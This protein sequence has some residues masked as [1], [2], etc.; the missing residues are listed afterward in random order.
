MAEQELEESVP[1]RTQIRREVCYSFIRTTVLP[2]SLTVG[3]S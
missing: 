3:L 1:N 2:P